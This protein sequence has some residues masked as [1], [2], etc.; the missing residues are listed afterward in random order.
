MASQRLV[1]NVPMRGARGSRFKC[2][3]RGQHVGGKVIIRINTRH[4]FYREVWKPLKEIGDSTPGT[5]YDREVVHTAKRTIETLT[6]LLITWGKAE[7]MN[8]NPLAQYG[9]LRN[10]WGMF[11]DT[12]MGKVKDVL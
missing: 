11:L 3:G 7:S 5:K 8:E 4:R 10:Y 9:E 1:A 2:L 12:M 6:L